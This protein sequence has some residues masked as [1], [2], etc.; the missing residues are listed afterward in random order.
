[1]SAALQTNLQPTQRSIIRVLY[2]GTILVFLAGSFEIDQAM[3]IEERHYL[4]PV[5][6][7]PY[8]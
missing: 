5:Q 8:H 7:L 3:R 2:R 1:M 6:M 4:C